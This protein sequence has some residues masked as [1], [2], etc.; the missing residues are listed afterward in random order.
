MRNIERLFSAILIICIVLSCVSIISSADVRKVGDVNS[1][2]NINGK[3]V[4]LLR[5]YIVGLDTVD[6]ER[7][8]D[9]IGDGAVN[10]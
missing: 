3:D 6:D 5:K 8:A 10:G 1:D 2:G 9:C 4:L 7:Y